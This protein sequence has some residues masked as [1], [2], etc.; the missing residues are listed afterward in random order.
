MVRG[1]AGDRCYEGEMQKADVGLNWE[2]RYR[3]RGREEGQIKLR[4]FGKSTMNH[5][6]LCLP[7]IMCNMCVYIHTHTLK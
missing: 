2:D 7:K 4:V 5:I 1:I 3:W 6:I